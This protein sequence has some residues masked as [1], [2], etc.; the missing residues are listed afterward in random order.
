MPAL[1][2]LSGR[3]FG[4][5]AVLQ[6]AGPSTNGKTLWLCRCVCGTRKEVIGRN[7]TNGRSNSC[8]CKAEELAQQKLATLGAR[9]M[10]D[11]PG[12]NSWSGAKDRCRD[13]K[14]KSY[15]NY[16]GRGIEFRLP[17]YPTF[18][19]HMKDTWFE[20][21]QLD[22]RKNAEHYE[23]GNVRWV[24]A[25]VNSRNTRVNHNI[26][27]NGET[28]SMTAWAERLNIPKATLFWRINAGWAVEKALTS[29]RYKV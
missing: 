23:L 14:D 6:K 28:M 7:L 20:G 21:A 9:V 13:P 29:K 17:D 24:T 4:A 10:H 18:W 15:K 22:R 19:K 12:Y 1:I 26:T 11:S 5:W 3:T 16:G 25:K 27:H 2:D 8:G